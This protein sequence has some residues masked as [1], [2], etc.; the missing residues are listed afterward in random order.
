MVKQK[1]RGHGEGSIYR[2]KDG[3]WAASITLEGRKRKTLYGKTRKEVYEKLQ[4]ALRDQ[5]QG[6]LVRG[7]K[8]TLKQYLEYW[9][10]DVHK[11]TIK[12]TSY[13][14]YRKLLNKHIL[15]ALGHILVQSLSPQQVQDFY[16]G[17]VKEGL[18]ASVVAAI[19]GL[20][21]N[22]LDNAVRWN[23]VSRNVCDVVSLPRSAKRE[24]Q[25]LTKEQ[26]QHLL[27]VARGHQLEGLLMVALTTGMRHG[28]LAALRWNDINF[29][30]SSLHIHRNVSY[31]AKYGFVES[32]P[33]TV[34]SRRKI[35]LPH[36]VVD[37]L[38]RHRENQDETR[39]K[40]GDT[41]YDLDLVFCN[42]YGRF[43]NPDA[44][45]RSFH[46][47]LAEAELPQMRLHDLRHSAATILL[48]MGAH[49]KVVQEILGHSQ[50]SMTMDT[51]SHVLPSMQRETMEK[52]NDLFEG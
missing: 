43:L 11:P 15:P 45:L 19:H 31:L 39:M 17:K 48:T 28:E 25:T 14:K 47:L 12:I 1:Q 7:T 3:R 51:Y 9:L 50:I 37:A 10:E 13:V 40:A 38:K 49:P 36:F 22:A 30:N 24:V 33:K 32:E 20:L 6:T 16:T 26:A 21:H 46:K 34:R 2:R 35:I 23:L 41:W 29:D 18:S 52:L 4:E 27:E 5:K 8:Q 44:L 42:S